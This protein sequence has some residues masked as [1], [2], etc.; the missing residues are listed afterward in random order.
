MLHGYVTVL[1]ISLKIGNENKNRGILD[2]QCNNCIAIEVYCV[3]YSPV[4]NGHCP[5]LSKVAGCQQKLPPIWLVSVGT[6]LGISFR[7]AFFK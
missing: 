7:M 3:V 5:G 2:K 4:F 6:L 1:R